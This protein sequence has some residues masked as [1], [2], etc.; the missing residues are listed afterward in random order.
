[1]PPSPGSSVALACVG[2]GQL[3]PRD[4]GPGPKDTTSVLHGSS[5]GQARRSCF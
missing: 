2:K 1:M 5:E 3:G 4:Q